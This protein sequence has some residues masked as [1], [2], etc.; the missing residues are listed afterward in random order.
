M[1]GEARCRALF[2]DNAL[3]GSEITD[4]F[5]GGDDSAL[6]ADAVCS[7]VQ[8]HRSN[9]DGNSDGSSSSTDGGSG[10]GDGGAANGAATSDGGHDGASHQEEQALPAELFARKAGRAIFHVRR[11]FYTPPHPLLAAAPSHNRSRS[12][13]VRIPLRSTPH[14]CLPSS[15]CAAAT[16]GSACSSTSPP[17]QW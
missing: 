8:T 3:G 6:G 13:L 4:F 11:C 14:T 12:I 7:F 5:C 10:D 16:G 1:G 2:G 17:S 15:T 9:G